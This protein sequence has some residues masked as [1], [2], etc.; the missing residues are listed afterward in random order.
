[1]DGWMDRMDKK[2]DGWIDEWIKFCMHVCIC[3]INLMALTMLRR[4]A[5]S[6]RVEDGRHSSSPSICENRCCIID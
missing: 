2:I 5:T 6:C 4:I 1:M 3:V